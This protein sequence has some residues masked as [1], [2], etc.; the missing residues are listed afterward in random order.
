[1]ENNNS[2]CSIILTYDHAKFYL[3][4]YLIWNCVMH[5]HDKR[6]TLKFH[7]K[8]RFSNNRWY[9][10]ILSILTLVHIFIFSLS[11]RFSKKAFLSNCVFKT[12]SWC[13]IVKPKQLYPFSNALGLYFKLYYQTTQLYFCCRYIQKLL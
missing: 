9:I 6:L 8:N 10:F 7:S 12:T 1:M 5:F 4:C 11:V 13:S 3:Q 2:K